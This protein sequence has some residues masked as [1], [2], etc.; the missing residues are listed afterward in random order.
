MINNFVLSLQ[1]FVKIDTLSHVLSTLPSLIGIEKYTIVIGIDSCNQ[2]RYKNR[3]H[4]PEQNKI[5]KNMIM[6]F[7]NKACAKKI[8]IIE[9]DTN[10]GTAPTCR[11]IIDYSMGLSDYVIFIEDDIIL[12][13]DA[14]LYHESVFELS[15]FNT[16]V[17]G[18]GCG[19][20]DLAHVNREPGNLYKL[21][22]LPWIDSAEFGVNSSIWHK[23]GHIRGQPQGAV[24]FG[25][26]CKD[27]S[28]YTICP[29]VKRL[30]RLGMDHPDSYSVYYHPKETNYSELCKPCSDYFDINVT[31]YH[32]L[33]HF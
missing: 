16:D 3:P 8:D 4:W 19:S 9:N 6:Q 32:N 21:Y 5:V 18:I 2:M 33:L 30:C 11:R 26:I 28:K 7:Q 20:I 31:D 27:E 29:K 13:R 23:Y 17:F 24:D 12:S 22:T 14:L 25:K 15:K 10:M 1:T